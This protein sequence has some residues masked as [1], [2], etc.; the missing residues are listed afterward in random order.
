MIL[1]AV[2]SHYRRHPLQLLALWLILTL[3]TALWSGVWSLTGQA[4]DSMTA[5]DSQLSGRQQVVRSDGAP[6]TVADFASLRRHGLCVFPWLQVATDDAR[7]QVVGIDPLAMACSRG[8]ATGS[9]FSMD[10]QP[11]VDIAEAAERAASGHSATLRLYVTKGDASLPEGWQRQGDPGGLS[12]GELSDSFL[13]NLD[14]LG[15]LVVLV[16]ALLIRSVYTL[17]LAQRRE[18]LGL[19]ERYGVTRRRLRLH[20]LL[21]LM[22]LAAL[23]VV[24]GYLLGQGLADVLAGGFGAALG[25][26]FETDLLATGE[27]LTGFLV[28][29]V[30]MILVVLWCGLDLL[31]GNAG[32]TRSKAHPVMGAV[33]ILAGMV[34]VVPAQSLVTVFL[35]TGLVLA[36]A[37]LMTPALLGWCL[38]PSPH[39]P[40]LKL[41]R[42]RELGVLAGRLAL[43]L[44][45]LQ[46]AAGTV[47]AVHALV[48]TFEGTF[49]EWLDQRLA[50]DVFVEVPEGK[51][52]APAATWLE[53]QDGVAQWHPVL[54]GAA[55]LGMN[56]EN[57]QVD[58]MATDTTSTLIRQWSLLASVSQPWQ[59]LAD[60]D[61]LVNEQLA[62]RQDL[63]PGSQLT[64]VIADKERVVEVVGV[65]ADYGRPAGEVLV[66]TRHLPDGFVSGFRSLTI[67]L[68][69]GSG[70]VSRSDLVAG[71]EAAWQ[72]GSLQVRDNET[73]HRLATRIF[74]Q[75]FALTRSISYLTLLLAGVALLMTGWVVLRSRAWYFGLLSAW[76]LTHR[77]RRQT[78]TMLTAEFMVAI[79]VAA[80]P[81]G[82]ALTWVLVDRIN[83]VA[84]GWTLPM[85]I[86]PGYWLELLLLFGLAAV[87]VGWLASSGR[88]EAPVQAP[89]LDGGQ[90]R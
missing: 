59:A 50:G 85:A 30:M 58:L 41:W 54:R 35:G 47:I 79:W 66:D 72:V 15:L 62:R 39:M 65:Y 4:R 12:T 75:T 42:R 80:L 73:I 22:V 10:G 17:G 86:Y 52:L 68:A 24:P 77:Q 2:L 26:L 37:G 76:G 51:P 27:S 6:V 20:L 31:R 5:G 9:G 34:L 82:I 64:L 19:L 32:R 74:D 71:L 89:R 90:E 23:G 55:G 16:S 43:P 3:A 25:N 18:S 49:H 28:T 45:A 40:P 61:V 46:L 60:G 1:R 83:P 29:L 44:V 67:D 7:G 21:E 84:F 48:S 36:G 88:T 69:D 57:R 14:A 78:I 63:K 56:G 87:V 13:L 53:S 70:G 11:F 38:S 81:V 8:A 33:L